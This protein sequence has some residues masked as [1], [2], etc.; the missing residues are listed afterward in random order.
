MC[1]IVP[2]ATVPDDA[3]RH[4]LRPVDDAVDAGWACVD[5]DNLFVTI[6]AMR[7]RQTGAGSVGGGGGSVGPGGSVGSGRI[8]VGGVGGS[9]GSGGVGG[10]G[11]GVGG[12]GCGSMTM[13]NI[14]ASSWELAGGVCAVPRPQQ[15]MH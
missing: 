7:E 2:R 1:R 5:R 3:V 12:K 8:G 13:A 10:V 4:V 15:C 6:P 11:D 14:G 9:W